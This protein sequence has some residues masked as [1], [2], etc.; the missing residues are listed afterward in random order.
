[1][2][3]K[4]EQKQ[5]RYVELLRSGYKFLSDAT[6]AATGAGIGFALGGP[7]GAVVGSVSSVAIPRALE[8]VGQE[9]SKRHLSKREEARAGG[10]LIIAATE[11][12]KRITRGENLR[13]DDF[14]CPGQSGRSDAEEVVENIL[15]KCQREPQ[16]KKIPFVGYLLASLA[17]RNDIS[18]DMA[19]LIIKLADELTYRQLCLLRI[20]TRTNTLELRDSNYRELGLFPKSLYPILHECF[21]LYHKELIN[22]GGEHPLGL[23][24]VWPAKMSTQGLGVDICDMMQ[25]WLIPDEEQNLIIRHLK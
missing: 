2:T 18:T 8:L 16:E 4:P 23:T 24:G 19:H 22:L 7:I 5:A 15:L 14:F 9:V 3:T 25:L 11:I 20:A 6:G 1:M 21:D 17:F 13:Q 10:V 12:Q